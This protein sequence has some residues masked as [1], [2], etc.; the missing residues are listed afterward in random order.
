MKKENAFI[1][2]CK[3]YIPSRIRVYGVIYDLI[4]SMGNGKYKLGYFGE[5]QIDNTLLVHEYNKNVAI[6]DIIKS[7]LKALSAIPSVEILDGKPL[8]VIPTDISVK[9][10][11]KNNLKDYIDNLSTLYEQAK[12]ENTRLKAEVINLRREVA[13]KTARVERLEKT[14]VQIKSL[15]N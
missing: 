2:I 1:K 3:L 5:T 11:V 8:G 12:N 9:M 13:T 15:T 14:I 6:D 4:P 7:Y 10:P